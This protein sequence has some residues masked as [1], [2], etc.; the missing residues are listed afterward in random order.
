MCFCVHDRT[1]VVGRHP[2][3]EIQGFPGK[4]TKPSPACR[5][6]PTPFVFKDARRLIAVWFNRFSADRGDCGPYAPTSGSSAGPGGDAMPLWHA[7]R[8]ALA[9]EDSPASDTSIFFC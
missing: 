8:H 5:S 2:R 1:Q 3:A 4:N 6:L 9:A 7:L